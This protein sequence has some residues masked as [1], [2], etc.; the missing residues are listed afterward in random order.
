ML[1]NKK[2]KLRRETSTCRKVINERPRTHPMRTQP[3]LEERNLLELGSLDSSSP[4]L[5]KA[6]R[7]F[8]DNV[9]KCSKCYDRKAKCILAFRSSK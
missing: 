8:G 4:F 2:V 7:V 1:K 9:L 3:D 6:I 5:L